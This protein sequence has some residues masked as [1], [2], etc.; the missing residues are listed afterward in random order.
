MTETIS[1]SSAR[2]SGIR[3]V[4]APFPIGLYVIYLYMSGRDL[5]SNHVLIWTE[6]PD[7]WRPNNGSRRAPVPP[8]PTIGLNVPYL[9]MSGVRQDLVSNQVLIWTVCPDL[10][11]QNNGS[12]RGEFFSSVGIVYSFTT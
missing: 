12:R 11:R 8:P 9:Y 4:D 5:M 2:A 1:L 7:L 10:W 3:T 6:R